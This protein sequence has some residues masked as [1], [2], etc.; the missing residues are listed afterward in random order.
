[1]TTTKRIRNVQPIDYTK[2]SFGEIKE[3]LVQY[4]K[5]HYPDTYKDFKKSSFGSMMLDLV[6]YVGD[7]LHYYLDHN[8]NE[9]IAAFTKDPDILIQLIQSFGADPTLN[10]V[11]VGEVSVQ[12]L[13]PADSFGV[14]LDLDYEPILRAGS[15]FRSQGGTVYTV[16]RDVTFNEQNSQ[17]IGYNTTEDGSKINY[18]ILKAQVPVISGEE[19][20]YSVDVG[21]F[22][23]FLKVEIPDPTVTEILKIETAEK[24]EFFQVD[25]LTQNVIYRPIL[26]PSSRDSMVS[27]IMK[28]T[29]TPRRFIVE[30]SLNRTHVVFGY[31]SDQDLKTNSVADPSSVAL[32]M[33]GKTYVSSPKLDPTN[34]FSSNKLGVAPQ[35]TTITIKYR[36]NTSGNANAAV[37]TVN[38]VVDAD[39]FFK[40]EQLLSA[41]KVSFI[42][43]N[44]QVYN[45]EPING[46]ISI[47]NTEELKRRY[48]GTFGAQSRAV[49]EQDYISAAYSMPPIYG[50]IKRA[51][52]FRDENDL[53]RN[54]NMYLMAEGA[55]G[56]MQKPSIL[57]KQN[58]KTWL[59]S[60]RMI[61]DSVDLFDAN[62]IN[63]GIDFRLSLKNNVNQKTAINTIKQRIFEELT[64]IAPEIGEP[65]YLT[66]IVRIIQNIP[67]VASI[68][69]KDGVK[70]TSLTGTNYTDYQYNVKTNTAPDNSYIYIPKN[71]IW[72]IKYIDDIK[73]TII[74]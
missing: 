69:A 20:T 21:N 33:S 31:G 61:S 34:L 68:S 50:S 5:R 9:S 6:S 66:E 37:G 32:K 43:D 74:G 58:V 10:P 35:N 42:K 11:G 51:S 59:D 41:A 40:N 72:E 22:R 14:G 2:T 30:K 57:L 55:D 44:I 70:I 48:L 24:D 49:T 29:P 23:R 19:R 15:R 73:G 47:P 67:E 17:I 45:E 25:H 4:I 38:Q 26:D 36:S 46:N 1:M 60:V 13:N 7:Q 56:K 39:L 52:V 8:A 54:L 63:F 16:M 64:T 28:P 18:Y 12:I 53:R 65:L 3:E 71:S 27:S 62:I